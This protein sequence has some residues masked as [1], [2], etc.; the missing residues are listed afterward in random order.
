MGL[1]EKVLGWWHGRGV[2]S[3][4]EGGLGVCD[5]GCMNMS[6][7]MKWIARLLRRD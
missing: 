3:V 4:Q 2:M 6:L 5:V 1:W 7:L